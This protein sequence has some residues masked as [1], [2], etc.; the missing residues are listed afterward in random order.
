[1]KSLKENILSSLNLIK[2]SIRG[3]ESNILEGNL[4]RAIILLAIPMMLEMLMESLFALVDIFFV[5]KIGV[6][7]VAAVGLTESLMTLIYSVAVGLSMGTT[8]MVARR[9]GENNLSGAAVA[10]AQALYISF[11]VSFITGLAGLIYAEELLKLMGA[12]DAVISEGI[13]Y[14]KIVISANF[15]V[16]LLFLINAI[17]RGAGDAALAM[18]ALWISNSIN[19]ILDPLM[20]FGI[21]PF[22]EMG[23]EGAA[24][25]TVIGRSVGVAYQCYHLFSSKGVIK[26]HKENIYVNTKVIKKLLVLSAGGTAQFLIGSASWIFLMRIMST[27]GSIALA[28]YTIAIRIVVFT[29]LP[30]WGISNA[31]STMV[32]QNLGA[33]QPERAEKS[34]WRT[35]FFNMIY[36]GSVMII[37]LLFAEPIVRFFTSDINVIRHAT[38]CLIIF[39]LGY[40]FYA[41]GMVIV[42]SFNGSGDTRT[43]TIINFFIFWT[44]QIPLAYLLAIYW[45]YGPQ[46]VYWAIPIAES[47][48]T[49]ISYFIFKRGKWK[50]IK[51]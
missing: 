12:S 33:A 2:Q 40:L 34:V 11:F 27:F 17:F 20:I 46:G 35:G 50:L 36:M 19:I 22:P 25:A 9:V 45:D 31:A 51:I 14:T 7:A 42:Q 32:G 48:L 6:N 16:M 29:L 8:A 5:S 18:R 13:G 1:M 26:F 10:G 49:I 15:I 44:F 47:T 24:I 28:G 38:Q 21:G 43:P 3:D 30:A 23:V 41:F 37:Y 4:N 39:S